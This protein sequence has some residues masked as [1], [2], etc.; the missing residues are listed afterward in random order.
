MSKARDK[1]SKSMTI[2]Q[3]LK[4]QSGDAGVYVPTVL[5]GITRTPCQ[6]MALAQILYW[7]DRDDQGKVRARTKHKRESGVW[8]AF[9]YEEW[10]EQCGLTKRQVT[11]AVDKLV[12][13]GIVRRCTHRRGATRATWLQPVQEYFDS[14]QEESD[15]LRNEDAP[16]SGAEA[17]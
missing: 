7:H 2:L 5:P 4:A 1:K 9:T 12:E 17:A 8:A 16:S 15:A 14:L 11:N 3:R 6:A 10:A 13:D